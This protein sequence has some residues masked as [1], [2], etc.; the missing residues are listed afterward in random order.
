MTTVV[1]ATRKTPAPLFELDSRVTLENLWTT[2]R[3]IL[4]VFGQ[5]ELLIRPTYGHSRP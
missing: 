4:A 3:A 2:M 5:H 1:I